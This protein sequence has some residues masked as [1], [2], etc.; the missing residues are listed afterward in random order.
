MKRDYAIQLNNALHAEGL[1]V[2]HLTGDQYIKLLALKRPLAKYANEMSEEE[3]ALYKTYDVI[4]NVDI[5]N[6]LKDKS[7]RDKRDAI[8]SK[9]FD[10]KELKFMDN[11]VFKKF[12]D[13]ID[14]GTA[15]ILAEYLLKE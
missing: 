1:K 14:F 4:T 3:Q 13:E 9:E 10:P 2:K 6:Q 5:L 15:S 11:E 12:T 8:F 7:F